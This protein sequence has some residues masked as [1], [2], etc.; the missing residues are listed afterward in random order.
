MF[1][2]TR[3]ACHEIS[4]ENLIRYKANLL[5]LIL[6]RKRHKKKFYFKKYSE[7]NERRYSD[8]PNL[9]KKKFLKTFLYWKLARVFS[10]EQLQSFLFDLVLHLEIN[11]ET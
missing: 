4:H 6:R 9:I 5:Y 1:I 10:V 3:P 11:F 8:E 7:E 2:F